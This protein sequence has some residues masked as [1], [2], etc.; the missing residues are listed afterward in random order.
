MK[1]CSLH[2]KVSALAVVMILAIALN[3]MLIGRHYFSVWIT[4]AK[5]INKPLLSAVHLPVTNALA[6]EM[7]NQTDIWSG[8]LSLISMVPSSG[9]EISFIHM[10][11]RIYHTLFSEITSANRDYT[12]PHYPD[13][14]HFYR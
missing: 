10:P 8:G 4:R 3:W 5:A 7:L 13:F 1:R 2:H 11:K 12:D 14:S 9:K 6:K